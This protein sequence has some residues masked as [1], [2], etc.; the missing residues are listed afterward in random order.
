MNSFKQKY[1]PWALVT[2][3]SS[4]LGAEFAKQLAAERINIV[5]VA[6][7]EDR[8]RALAE[9]LKKNSS[10]DS[11]VVSADLSQDDFL[12]RINEAT[13]GLEINLLVN[14][15][16]SVLS[17]HFLSHDIQ[18]ELDIL[19]LNSRAPMILT[20]HFGKLMKSREK[21]GI[22]FVASVVGLAGIPGWTNYASTKGQ[23]LLF[24]EGLGGELKQDGVDVLALAPAFIR[25][26]FMELTS[27]GK[28]MSLP[29]DRVV[30][31]ALKNLG[32]KRVVTPGLI[33]KLI[34]FSTR[35]QPRFLNT[36][37]F[38]AVISASQ[39]S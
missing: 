20:H 15:A 36:K 14:N 3:A 39:G 38:R 18:S 34:A 35:L 4:G 10:V 25:S 11:R 26:E 31:V 8:L 12:G 9:E 28:F 16:G 24:A 27:F 30:R 17:D 23:N 33:H 7:R 22:I 19:Y 21:G 29:V 13:T 6:R 2:G 37:I 1:G 32:K 5:L